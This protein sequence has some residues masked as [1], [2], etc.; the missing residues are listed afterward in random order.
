MNHRNLTVAVL[1]AV[2]S[3]PVAL[4]GAEEKKK[5]G[6]FAAMDTDKDGKVSKKEYVAAQKDAAKAESRF[7]QLDTDKDGFLTR[8]EMA[9]GQKKK[10]K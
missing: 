6:G 10:D 8:A 1:T 7:A 9:A 4:V 5:G 3:L 2:L